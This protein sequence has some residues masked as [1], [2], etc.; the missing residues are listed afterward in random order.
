MGM[1]SQLGL[2]DSRDAGVLVTLV[3]ALDRSMTGLFNTQLRVQGS[4]HAAVGIVLVPAQ[5]LHGPRQPFC[6]RRLFLREGHAAMRHPPSLT[7]LGVLDE[8]IL[9]NNVWRSLGHEGALEDA[10]HLVEQDLIIFIVSVVLRHE[11]LR[12]DLPHL[13]GSPPTRWLPFGQH[14]QLHL[15]VLAAPLRRQRRQLAFSV[16]RAD[17]LQKLLGNLQFLRSHYRGIVRE[18][19]RAV[20]ALQQRA[21]RLKAHV[22]SPHLS[23]E[24][25]GDQRARLPRQRHLEHALVVPLNLAN[26]THLLSP[27][28]RLRGG[29]PLACAHGRH[30]RRTHGGG[31]NAAPLVAIEL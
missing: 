28:G 20:A 19:E 26:E 6:S 24:A 3:H 9:R 18:S 12:C 10:L 11:S 31:A 1:N 17:A 5:G 25:A 22:P 13:A 7:L 2:Q 8:P 4:R 15:R 27:L 29:R 30:R 14:A 16:Y 21:Q 23:V